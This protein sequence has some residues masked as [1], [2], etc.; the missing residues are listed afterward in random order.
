[1]WAQKQKPRLYGCRYYYFF[2]FFSLYF[3]L[4]FGQPEMAK[5]YEKLITKTAFYNVHI[6]NGCEYNEARIQFIYTHTHT[7]SSI[8]LLKGSLTLHHYN[9]L[10]EEITG[11]FSL[12]HNNNT[13]NDYSNSFKT[14]LRI[15]TERISVFRS[16]IRKKRSDDLVGGRAVSMEWFGIAR[17]F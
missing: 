5:K 13:K 10:D 16:Q 6:Q 9:G 14:T 11:N 2:F 12:Y 15:F 1:M 4:L 8:E 17:K 3:F 7:H